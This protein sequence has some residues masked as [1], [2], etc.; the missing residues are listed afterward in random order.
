MPP[1]RWPRGG[2]A[3]SPESP[4]S[5]PEDVLQLEDDGLGPLVLE[6]DELSFHIGT[7][8]I[9]D[10]VC[11]RTQKGEL[12]AVLGESG[13]GKST[14]LNVLAGRAAYGSCSGQLRLNGSTFA[15]EASWWASRFV[16]FVEQKYIVFKELTVFENLYYAARLRLARGTAASVR[17]ELIESTLALL[18]LASPS[19][20]R[21]SPSLASSSSTSRRA[22]S[23]QSTLR[24]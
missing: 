5:V 22:R 6:V 12:T 16:S 7:K 4:Q 24:S 2:S 10:R 1:T 8:A 13:S 21:W 9:L 14:L 18:G 23:M 20:S 17:Y 11:V 15:S 19:A 3:A